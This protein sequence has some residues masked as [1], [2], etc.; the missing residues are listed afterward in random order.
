MAHSAVS[1]VELDA[2]SEVVVGRLKG[3]PQPLSVSSYGC[4]QRAFCAPC[5]ELARLHVLSG[6]Q[7]ACGDEDVAADHQ[8][9]EGGH[10]TDDESLRHDDLLPRP[11]FTANA[12]SGPRARRHLC[13]TAIALASREP[14]GPTSPRPWQLYRI[15]KSTFCCSRNA[16][17]PGPCRDASVES[18]PAST[19]VRA[20]TV[21]ECGA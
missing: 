21:N 9:H 16:R 7:P 4:P 1:V 12:R 2:C 17:A 3:A 18:V 13:C 14:V 20:P 10:K 8:N 19:Q 11:P 5:L 15:Q 6:V